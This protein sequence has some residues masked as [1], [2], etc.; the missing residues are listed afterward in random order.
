[1]SIISL[2][3]RKWLAMACVM[4]L[5]GAS[6]GPALADYKKVGPDKRSKAQIAEDECSAQANGSKKVVIGTIAA[7]LI[8]MMIARDSYIKDCMESRGYKKI[9]KK[10]KKLEYGHN[11]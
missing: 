9:A 4:A 11:R 8:G 1:M 5:A 7:G 6:I 2:S 3:A 10:K